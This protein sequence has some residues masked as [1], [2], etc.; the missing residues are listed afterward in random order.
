[1]RSWQNLRN[2]HC[3]RRSSLTSPRRSTM[4]GTSACCINWRPP[5]QAHTICSCSRTL[6]TVTSRSGIM[7][8]ALTATRWGPVPPRAVFLAPC[9]T[10]HRRSTHDA[11][12]HHRD[13]CGWHGAPGGASL[14]C[15]RIPV[16]PE[17]LNPSAQ[18]V[19]TVENPCQPGEVCTCYLQHTT[20]YLPSCIFAHHP[21]PS[22]IRR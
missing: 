16:P 7:A 11:L 4:C 5:S 3:A 15:R 19:R 17:P 9:S 13:F 22:K 21:D 1:M 8:C 10:F 18:L 14:S 6:P 20:R 12:H 2:A